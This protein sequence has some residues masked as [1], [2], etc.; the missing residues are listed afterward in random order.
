MAYTDYE[1]SVDH[2]VH[3]ETISS[4]ATLVWEACRR[5]VAELKAFPIAPWVTRGSSRAGSDGTAFSATPDGVDHWST[6]T[7]AQVST[8]GNERIWHVLENTVTGVQVCIEVRPSSDIR[9]TVSKNKFETAGAWRG[10]GTDANTR[11]TDTGSTPA[12]GREVS[13]TNITPFVARTAYQAG[14]SGYSI[15]VLNRKDGKGF[16]FY[17]WRLPLIQDST[18]GIGAFSSFAAGVAPAMASSPDINGDNPYIALYSNSDGLTSALDTGSPP[19][20]SNGNFRIEGRRPDGTL[21]SYALRAIAIPTTPEV[22]S[23]RYPVAPGLLAT[24]NGAN[25]VYRG[26]IPDVWVTG[27]TDATLPWLTTWNAFAYVKFGRTL[28]PWDGV[29]DIGGGTRLGYLLAGSSALA[30]FVEEEEE[31]PTVPPVTFTSTLPNDDEADFGVDF[32]VLGELPKSFVL[33]SGK[34]N[35][36]NAIARRLQTPAGFLDDAHGGDPDYGLDLR[37]RLNGSGSVEELAA[38]QADIKD[39][40]E[41][42]ARVLA[43]DVSAD[44]TIE[45]ATLSVQ[46]ALETGEGPFEMVL[47]VSAVTTEVLLAPST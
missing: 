39:E 21:D 6:R 4:T 31:E 8:S 37:G 22:G 9:I 10:G 34:R 25:S 35:L 23:S 7:S 18:G 13:T 28:W 29:T 27:T 38:L 14:A 47:N 32:D 36:A 15:S 19:E 33:A 26:G 45:T 17:Y 43:A 24:A 3:N 16:Y 5:A 30:S 12:A 41:K 40:V 1:P 11:P 42:D 2:Q 46:I 44:Y 20:L